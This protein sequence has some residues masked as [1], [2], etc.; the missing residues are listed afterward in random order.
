MSKNEMELIGMIREH[1]SPDKALMVAIGVITDFLMQHPE[2][3]EKRCILET[4]E[5][6]CYNGHMP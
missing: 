3:N 1:D 4:C 6:M 5:Q 2:Y